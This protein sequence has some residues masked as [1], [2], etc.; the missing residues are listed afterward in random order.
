MH[1]HLVCHRDLKPSNIL[2]SEDGNILKVTDFNVSKFSEGFK[3]FNNFSE[4]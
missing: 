1:E 4:E 2:C 3:E